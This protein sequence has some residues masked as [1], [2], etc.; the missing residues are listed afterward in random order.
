[1][2]SLITTINILKNTKV[3]ANKKAKVKA[4]KTSLQPMV[5]AVG[6][7]ELELQ[8]L[9]YVY[10]DD[11]TYQ[12]DNLLDAVSLCF[13]LIHVIDRD[14]MDESFQVWRFIERYFYEIE[15]S[16]TNTRIDN[17]IKTL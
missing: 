5:F 17:L 15:S 12:F 3:E 14:Y 11:I 7:S 13:K 4:E 10:I 1:M 2:S 9:F 6:K 8:K 16:W